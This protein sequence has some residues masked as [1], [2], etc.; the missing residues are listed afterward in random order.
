V[1]QLQF[2]SVFQVAE[3]RLLPPEKRPLAS[4]IYNEGADAITVARVT[5]QTTVA[6]KADGT[7]IQCGFEVL[8]PQPLY[9]CGNNA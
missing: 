1:N 6:E 7:A 9:Q 4:L 3:E 5:E 8:L 2:D